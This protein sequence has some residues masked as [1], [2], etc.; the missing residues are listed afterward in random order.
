MG[1]IFENIGNAKVSQ[2]DGNYVRPGHYYARLNAVK[3]T[4]KFTGEQFLAVEMTVVSVLD[5]DEGRGH[6]VGEDTTHLMK[7]AS[8]SFLGNVKAFIAATLGC[9]PDEVD[10]NSADRVTSDEQ[11]LAGIVV[12]LVG[13]Q[14][15][16]KAGKPFTKVTYKREV[17]PDELNEAA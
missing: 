16:T 6:K 1:N 10:Q 14:I 4:Q 15:T 13:R 12:E 2:G 7:A 17:P 11:P 5:D 8:P 3:L 9:S